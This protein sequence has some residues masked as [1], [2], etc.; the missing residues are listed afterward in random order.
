MNK[1]FAMGLV[2]FTATSLFSSCADDR[3][4]NPT[5]VQPKEFRLNT[6]ISANQLLDLRS[7]RQINLV[8]SHPDATDKGA[9]LAGAGFYAVQVSKTGKFT[10]SVAQAD[11]DK[12]G[13]AVAD[14]IEFDQK[15]SETSVSIDAKVFDRALNVLYSWGEEERVPANVE[16]TVRVNAHFAG[17]N[18][19][20]EDGSVSIASNTVKMTVAPYYLEDAPIALNYIVGDDVAGSWSDNVADAGKSLLPFFPIPN[21]TYER[22]TGLGKVDY[23]GYFPE[24]AKFKVFSPKYTPNGMNFDWN[25]A[26]IAEHG[27]KGAAYYRNGSDDGGA[28]ITA[29][30]AGYYTIVIDNVKHTFTMSEASKDID[31]SDKGSIGIV[32]DFNG[33]NN[34]LVMNLASKPEV[35]KNAKHHVWSADLKLEA[36]SQVKFRANKESKLVWGS[37]TVLPYGVATKD[38]TG[39][40]L[41]KGEYRVYFNDL[42]GQYNFIL[43]EVKK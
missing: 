40:K 10:T 1:I 12:T 35:A 11:A 43:K 3:E 14:Y 13:M 25:Y 16:L 22:T 41:K 32:G 17:A 34:D 39:I 37:S 19:P 2:V 29:P 27:S 23:T 5:L 28:N 6:P 20:V 26:Y 42:T 30:S 18:T 8:W 21:T 31:T 24:G 9:P 7:S 4:S 15:F 36:P 38:G 33:W